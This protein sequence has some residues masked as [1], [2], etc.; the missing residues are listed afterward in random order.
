M[1]KFLTELLRGVS[2]ADEDA[3]NHG[4]AQRRRP[5]QGSRQR[6]RERVRPALEILEERIAPG[7][8]DWN[9]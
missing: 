6:P 1:F 7:G 3:G 8:G 4:P 5:E 9:G 2:K